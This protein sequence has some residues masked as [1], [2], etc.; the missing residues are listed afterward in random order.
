MSFISGCYLW[1][2]TCESK[3]QSVISNVKALLKYTF[4]HL[5]TLHQ[6]SEIKLSRRNIAKSQDVNVSASPLLM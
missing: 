5:V 6:H 4:S 3:D 1:F 2:M